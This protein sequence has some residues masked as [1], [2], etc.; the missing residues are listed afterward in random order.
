MENRAIPVG[1]S[2]VGRQ[3]V[4]LL[5]S[6]RGCR[7]AEIRPV[8]RLASS[9]VRR[10]PR[11]LL[12]GCHR[13]FSW[14]LAIGGSRQAVAR[15]SPG[16]VGTPVRSRSALVLPSADRLRWRSSRRRPKSAFRGGAICGSL[17]LSAVGF[18]SWKQRCSDELGY[19]RWR[20]WRRR[21][22][23][24]PAARRPKRCVTRPCSAM[25]AGWLARL[26]GLGQQRPAEAQ[27]QAAVRSVE[28]DSLDQE[29][30]ARATQPADGFRRDV[31]RRLLARPRGQL[32]QFHHARRRRTAPESARRSDD[33]V[34]LA[35]GHPVAAGAGVDAVAAADRLGATLVG[36]ISTVDAVF[37]GW[38]AAFVS[39]DPVRRRRGFGADRK[40]P[41][42]CQIR[43]FGRS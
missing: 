38:A 10:L 23:C 11:T 42:G 5:A 16:K 7:C 27:R 13:D 9:A 28:S 18:R 37:Q 41:P 36:S 35:R 21:R 17:F 31:R 40:R 43:R 6:R 2:R 29:R 19:F 33:S 4:P 24:R 8:R 32:G 12:D 30:N 39:G 34:E 20:C 26:V 25:A 14:D 3:V 22:C 1:G 15:S